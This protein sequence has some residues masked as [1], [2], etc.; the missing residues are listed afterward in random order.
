MAALEAQI[1]ELEAGVSGG[2]DLAW[3][4]LSGLD[5]LLHRDGAADPRVTRAA[6]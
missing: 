2:V 3:L 6:P 5:A 1:A 4:Y